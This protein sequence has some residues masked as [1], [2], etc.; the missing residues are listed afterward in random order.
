MCW[1]KK[2]A[3]IIPLIGALA[4][5]IEDDSDERLDAGYSDGYAVG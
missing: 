4:G 1:I 5:C 2:H 3:I